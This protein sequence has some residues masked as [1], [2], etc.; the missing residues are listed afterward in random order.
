[1]AAV[2]ELAQVAVQLATQYIEGFQTMSELSLF[3]WSLIYCFLK[4]CFEL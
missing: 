4:K 2:S 3:F 1:M